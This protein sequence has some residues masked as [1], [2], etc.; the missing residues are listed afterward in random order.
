MRMIITMI[1]NHI[2]CFKVCQWFFCCSLIIHFTW[3]RSLIVMLPYLSDKTWHFTKL[4]NQKKELINKDENAARNL[5][6]VILEVKL[7][8]KWNYRRN[9]SLQGWWYFSTQETIGMESEEL[10][11][12][13]L[14]DISEESGCDVMKHIKLWRGSDPGKR[15]THWKNSQR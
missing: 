14:I 13:K 9:S 2:P 5:R 15:I 10:S 11:K 7:K 1:T 8:C 4:N 12:G 6:V 3:F